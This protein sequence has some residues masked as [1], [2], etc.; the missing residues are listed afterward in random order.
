MQVTVTIYLLDVSWTE[1]D[2][3]KNIEIFLLHGCETSPYISVTVIYVISDHINSLGCHVDI[4]SDRAL[5]VA[6]NSTDTIVQ[7]FT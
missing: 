1:L 6:K 4:K 7:G 5:R 2:L 3:Y